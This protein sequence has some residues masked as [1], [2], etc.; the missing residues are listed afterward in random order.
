MHQLCMNTAP[1]P[2]PPADAHFGC[3]LH[4]SSAGCSRCIEGI[5]HRLS[6]VCQAS[7]YSTAD[8]AFAAVL[9]SAQS[10]GVQLLASIPEL[11]G[12]RKSMI[13][14]CH[15]VMAIVPASLS[16]VTNILL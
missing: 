6:L 8:V 3:V 2:S 16:L 4:A 1:D 12:M 13:G 9:N 14:Q 11:G 7:R 15:Q 5:F 10:P